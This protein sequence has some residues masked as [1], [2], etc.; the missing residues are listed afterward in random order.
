MNKKASDTLE[1]LIPV[2]LLLA[3]ILIFAL[4]LAMPEAGVERVY[5]RPYLPLVLN[6]LLITAIS[7]WIAWQSLRGYLAS[8]FIPFLVLG[9][10]LLASGITAFIAGLQLDRPPQRSTASGFFC[11]HCFTSSTPSCWEGKRIGW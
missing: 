1:R 10:A 9:C 6:T 7:F 4:M 11:R 5:Y 8:G 2:P 3:A